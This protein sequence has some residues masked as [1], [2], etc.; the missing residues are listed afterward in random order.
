MGG[1]D[2]QR[3]LRRES[4]PQ[5]VGQRR[6]QGGDPPG[7]QA[8]RD[9]A[10]QPR[11]L[12]RLPDARQERHD[13]RERVVLDRPVVRGRADHGETRGRLGRV[14]IE[15]DGAPGLRHLAPGGE[16][17]PLSG[18]G[19]TDGDAGNRSGEQDD[20]SGQRGMTVSH[21]QQPA[22]PGEGASG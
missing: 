15:A 8:A 3:G 20:G 17:R 21:P 7:S 13:P 2:A 1:G 6:G 4:P 12:Q 5:E 9:L 22:A 18:I 11:H 16:Q 19:V 10:E 14:P